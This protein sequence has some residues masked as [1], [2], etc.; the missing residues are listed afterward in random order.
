MDAPGRTKQFARKLRRELSLPE[1]ILWRALRGGRLE[2]IRFRRQH[3][4]GRYVLDFYSDVAKLAVEIDGAHH[5]L[6]DRPRRDAERDAWVREHG[7]ETLRVP[8][9]DVLTDADGVL[10]LILETA[11]RRAAEISGHRQARWTDQ[12]RGV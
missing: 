9:I 10:R 11:K 6:E 8:A 3:P 12:G 2:G 1:V 5:T 7:V 4:I